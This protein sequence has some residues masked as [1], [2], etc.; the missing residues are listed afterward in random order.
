MQ[1][2]TFL[3]YKKHLCR[4]EQL[5]PFDISADKVAHICAKKNESLKQTNIKTDRL[6]K[7]SKITLSQYDRLRIKDSFFLSLCIL[8]HPLLVNLPF[9]SSASSSSSIGYLPKILAQSIR[10]V[11]FAIGVPMGVW[12]PEVRVKPLGES[13]ALRMHCLPDSRTISGVP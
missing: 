5:S 4:L 9:Y 7:K 10:A 12:Q 11:K 2:S 13:Q 8:P 6:S 3:F 1:L